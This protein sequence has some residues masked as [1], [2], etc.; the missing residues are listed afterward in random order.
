MAAAKSG[1]Y[2]C[3]R[4][5]DNQQQV[6]Y[7]RV[8]ALIPVVSSMGETILPLSTPPLASC[9]LPCPPCP[10]ASAADLALVCQTGKEADS[11]LDFLLLGKRK[12]ITS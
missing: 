9:L 11:L 3:I 2:L 8:M 12:C 5:S 10:P 6:P 1:F 7:S 4:R